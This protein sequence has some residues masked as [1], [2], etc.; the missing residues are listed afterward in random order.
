MSISILFNIQEVSNLLNV[1]I[2]RIIIWEKNKK[3]IPV[4]IDNNG[5][6]HYSKNQLV[7]FEAANKV[8]SSSWE[9]ELMTRPTRDYNSIEL[10]AGGGGMALGF[11]KAGIHHSLLNEIDKYACSTLRTNRPNWNIVEGKIENIDFK[12]YS[13]SVDVV[14]GGFPCQAFSSAGKKGGFKDSRGT[15]FFE[16]TRCIKEVKPSVFVG[17]NVKGLFHHDK[18]NTLKVIKAKIK[19]LGYTLIEPRVLKAMYYKVP[20]KRERLFFVGVRNDLAENI[21]HFQFPSPY[22]KVLTV[23]DAFYKGDLFDSDVPKSLGVDYPKRK[24]EIMELI[25]EGGYWKDLSDKLQREYMG[26]SYFL[27]GGKTGIARRLSSK[28][29]SLTLVCSPAMKQTERCHPTETRP[30]TVRESAR[31][32]T[33]PDNWIFEG[34]KAEAYKQIGNAVPVNLAWAMGRSVV[35]LLNEIEKK[36]VK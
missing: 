7:P 31:I 15:L 36:I 3:L 24:R 13:N 11:E 27:G 35:K 12:E 32:Q 9:E 28:A 18:G 29:P 8:F 20:Q 30:L 25:P 16:F 6:R 21:E 17:E 1:S 5:I 4:K 2:P 23:D 14:T 19:E 10:F 33:F 22:S 34:P 26:G